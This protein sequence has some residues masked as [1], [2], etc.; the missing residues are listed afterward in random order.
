MDI[1]GN[2]SFDSPVARV[3]EVLLDPDTLARCLPGCEELVPLGNDE[4][5]AN[6]SVSVGSIKGTYR[7]K[8]SLT[9]RVP[10]CSY[11][12]VVEGTGSPGFVRGEALI[13]LEER[14]GNTLLRVDAE[15]QIGGTI[16][17]VGQR[18]LG[19]VSKLMM[20]R[21]FTRLGEAAG[22]RAPGTQPE[23]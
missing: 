16:A 3:W 10:M 18:L 2:Y 8:I 23:S 20:D 11:K 6:L 17:R 1:K 12:L 13:S 21:F 4:Y 19:S 15:A 7:A 14:D 5:E 22:L 9:D